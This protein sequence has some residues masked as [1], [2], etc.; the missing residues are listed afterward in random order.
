MYLYIFL[1][2]RACQDVIANLALFWKIISLIL[3]FGFRI[4]VYTRSQIV[5]V[6]F[7]HIIIILFIF[8]NK[9]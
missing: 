1:F 2:K 5:R 4:N 9:K 6:Y 7:I 8:T 3:V